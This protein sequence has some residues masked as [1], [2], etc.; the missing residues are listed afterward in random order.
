MGRCCSFDKGGI[1]MEEWAKISTDFDI[2][3]QFILID[4]YSSMPTT[5]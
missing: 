4:L 5:V 3:D 2:I 1:K